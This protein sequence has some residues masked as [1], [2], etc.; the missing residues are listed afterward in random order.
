MKIYVRPRDLQGENKCFPP[1]GHS[2]ISASMIYA[3]DRCQKI[4]IVVCNSYGIY[5]IYIIYGIYHRWI[6]HR[7]P[8]DPYPW[9]IGNEYHQKDVRR[10]SYSLTFTSKRIKSYVE[11]KLTSLFLLSV[12]GTKWSSIIHFWI[13]SLKQ[14]VV[15]CSSRNYKS[16]RFFSVRIFFR[17]LTTDQVSLTIVKVVQKFTF[18]NLDVLGIGDVF[19]QFFC[20]SSQNKY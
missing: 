7:E 10:F 5:T 13:H 11:T 1:S 9:D 8:S 4:D 3:S 14:M 17:N 16:V 15:R 12:V 19:P 2:Y 6:Y 20:H 18:Q